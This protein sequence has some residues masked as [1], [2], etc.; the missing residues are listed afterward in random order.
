MR[1]ESWSNWKPFWKA[2]WN[3]E[4]LQD[5]YNNEYNCAGYVLPKFVHCMWCFAL[6]RYNFE[7]TIRTMYPRVIGNEHEIAIW[8][9]SLSLSLSTWLL[10]PFHW[11]LECWNTG[12]RLIEICSVQ[13]RWPHWTISGRKIYSLSLSFEPQGSSSRTSVIQFT[14]M[15]T[16]GVHLQS[17]SRWLRL[18]YRHHSNNT[19]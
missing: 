9:F 2:V 11:L 19:G 13:F 17:D 18:L 16:S 8:V 6:F 5:G 10:I 12:F 3:A 14:T 1:Y 15:V 7:V 4:L